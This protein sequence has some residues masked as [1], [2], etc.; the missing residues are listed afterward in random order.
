[1]CEL[2]SSSGIYLGELTCALTVVELDSEVDQVLIPKPV[3][4]DQNVFTRAIGDGQFPNLV[5]E[6]GHG[7]EVLVK[8]RLELHVASASLNTPLRHLAE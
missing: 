8:L 5:S 6:R 7:F 4:E 1:M 2:E 3:A